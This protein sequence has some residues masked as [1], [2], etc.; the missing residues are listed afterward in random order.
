MGKRRRLHKLRVDKLQPDVP[1]K[2]KIPLPLL[3]ALIPP[4]K[5]HCLLEHEPAVP[6]LADDLA[7]VP[8]KI[9][10]PPQYLPLNKE[11][12]PFPH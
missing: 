1:P 10:A 7:P 3:P 8:A 2:R 4:L 5:R 9:T 6:L 11:N 12:R